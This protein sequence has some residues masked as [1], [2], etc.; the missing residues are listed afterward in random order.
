MKRTP[1]NQL[2]SVDILT[3]SDEKLSKGLNELRVSEGSI[4][5]IEDGT[6]VHPSSNEESKLTKWETEFELEINRYQIKYNLLLNNE[7]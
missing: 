2:K 7:D 4:M 6:I 1:L 3:D 5:Y